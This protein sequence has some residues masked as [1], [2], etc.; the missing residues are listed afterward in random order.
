MLRKPFG[1]L[2]SLRFPCLFTTIRNLGADFQTIY[3]RPELNG[4]LL[5]H[6]FY[7]ILRI[8]GWISYSNNLIK[9][10]YNRARFILIHNFLKF[11]IISVSKV[12][13]FEKNWHTKLG[14]PT[15]RTII[16]GQIQGCDKSLLKT[17]IYITY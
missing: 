6:E 7:L 4:K 16:S 3:E 17:T 14:S 8:F 10:L 15:R 1:K 2:F 5:K 9:C 13:F 12:P 11:G